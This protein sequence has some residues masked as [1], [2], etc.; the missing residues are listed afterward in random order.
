MRQLT[1]A[2]LSELRRAAGHDDGSRARNRW[3]REL[4]F[5]ALVDRGLVD[6]QRLCVT[7]AGHTAI[8]NGGEYDASAKLSE[9]AGE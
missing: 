9:G 2:Q 4:I 7:K 8:E 5:R 6:P 1:H 3:Q